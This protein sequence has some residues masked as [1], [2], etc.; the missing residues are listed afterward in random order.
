M[1]W[2]PE[3]LTTLAAF[4]PTFL[5]VLAM[6][7]QLNRVEVRLDQRLSDLRQSLLKQNDDTGEILRG[8]IREAKAELCVEI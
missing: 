3:M 8:E 2:T 5:A 7:W 6:L 4:A 1:K